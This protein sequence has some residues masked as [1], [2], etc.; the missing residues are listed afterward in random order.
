MFIYFKKRVNFIMDIKAIIAKN[1]SELRVA[2][3]MTQ[4]TLAEKLN[5]SDKAVSKWEH[6]ESLPD[7]TVLVSIAE[8]FGV[9]LDYLVKENHSPKDM[10][11]KK[12]IM[13]KYSR[14]VITMVSLVSIWLAAVLIFVLISL[15][16]KE[17][18]HQWLTFIY[19]IPVTSIVWLVL[20]SV[21]FN[22]KRNYLIISL[23][24]WSVLICIQLTLYIFGI[25]V[26]L[27]YL[28]GGPAQI[29]ILLC[30]F[31]KKRNKTK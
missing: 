17:A 1:I 10:P 19:A 26:E 30:A 14:G 8:L 25:R 13:H 24:M 29:I 7:I 4:L 20:N 11:I 22:T 9:S 2:S 6:G 18:T 28:V 23:L 5:Y 15:I 27:I 12:R 31:I 16:F 21:W 3:G